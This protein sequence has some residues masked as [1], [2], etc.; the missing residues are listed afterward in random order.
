MCMRLQLNRFC[1]TE[2]IN[3]LNHIRITMRLR[4]KNVTIQVFI[5]NILIKKYLR[6]GLHN[7]KKM[8]KSR[9]KRFYGDNRILYG[10]W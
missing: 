6:V 1:E 10:R 4:K 5:K 3:K 7:E 8:E 9:A 2:Y